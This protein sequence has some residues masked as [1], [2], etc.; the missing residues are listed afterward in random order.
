[1]KVEIGVCCSGWSVSWKA[2][3]IRLKGQEVK[4]EIPWLMAC[5]SCHSVGELWIG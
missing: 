4:G 3:E 1:M 2:Q 5:L